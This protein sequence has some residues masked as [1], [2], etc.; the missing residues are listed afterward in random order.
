MKTAGSQLGRDQIRASQIEQ[1]R[2]LLAEIVPSNRF[3]SSK[4]SA[5]GLGFDVS[6]IDDFSRRFPFTTKTEITADQAAHPPF[7]TNLT[8]PLD[9]YTR[10]HQT[11]GTAGAPLR[12][13]DTAESWD[14]MV[15]NWTEIFRAAGVGREDRI[16]FPFT[17]GPFIGFWLAFESGARL[18]AL[19]IPGGGLRTSARLQA[20]L[21]NKATV[22][23]CTPTYALRMAEVAAEEKIDLRA[24]KVLTLIVAGEPGG[25]IPEMRLR[26]SK[27]WN[28]AKIFDHHGMTE[29][30]PVT[31][32]CPDNP[33]F[34]HILES[35]YYAEV[36]V[37]GGSEAA[38]PGA[39]G[40]LVLTTLGRMGSP[41]LRYRTGDLVKALP[42]KMC[43]CGSNEWTLEG[44]ILGRV[45]DMVVVRGVNV[46]PSAVEGIVRSVAGIL[47][48]RVSLSQQ[49]GLAE[50]KVEIEAPDENARAELERAFQ[51][52][53]GLRVAVATVAPGALP[54]PE[55]KSNRWLIA[56]Q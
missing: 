32:E 20:I 12:W 50:M 9:R 22:L 48:Y 54:R 11:S 49:K 37:P 40:E 44:G 18:G 28:G 26:L 33:G 4:F 8:Y 19:C 39:S 14:W 27:A 15:E 47:E 2:S 52:A 55:M 35:S 38:S 7:G 21:D 24:S 25:S 45:D 29:A 31:Y 10:F 53:L 36:I 5:A 34:L 56:R 16:Y 23:C 42:L 51:A 3:Y 46:F 30:G 13:L 41:L 17:F 43:S 6:S 1:L